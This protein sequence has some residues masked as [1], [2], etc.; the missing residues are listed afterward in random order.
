MSKWLIFN[1]CLLWKYWSNDFFQA[2]I[3]MAFYT[4]PIRFPQICLQ[5][6]LKTSVCL[7]MWRKTVETKVGVQGSGSQI[8]E[9]GRIRAHVLYIVPWCSPELPPH[10]QSV[11]LTRGGHWTQYWGG[12]LHLWLN[13][14]HAQEKLDSSPFG[15]GLFL[16]IYSF[17]VS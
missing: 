3:N 17:E 1:S 5:C 7:M 9:T 13:L 15:H 11:E 6:T 8:L 4:E 12:D 14:S 16:M 2:C 10:S